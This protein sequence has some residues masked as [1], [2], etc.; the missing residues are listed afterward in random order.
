MELR[1]NH[2]MLKGEPMKKA[3]LLLAAI[4]TITACQSTQNPNANLNSNTSGQSEDQAGVRDE[5]CLESD[6][7][8]YVRHIFIDSGPKIRTSIGDIPITKDHHKVVWCVRNTTNKLVNVVI[9]HF[10][11]LN[12]PFRN[13]PFGNEQ[14]NE[15]MFMTMPI[16]AGSLKNIATKTA[17]KSGTYEYDVLLFDNNGNPADFVDPQVVISDG[18]RED[19]LANS[20]TAARNANKN[21]K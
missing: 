21:R 3:L 19:R 9:T 6:N 2:N 13:H 4:V 16:S 8:Q 12:D 11:E 10:H 17:K 7:Q 1:R 5:K 14:L 20:N 15:N 18:R